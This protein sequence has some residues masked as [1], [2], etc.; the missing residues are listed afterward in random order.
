[1]ADLSRPWTVEGM[2]A[3]LSLSGEHL[4]RLCHRQLN[5]SPMEHV[6][7]LRMIRAAAMLVGSTSKIDAIA[8]ATGYSTRFAFSTAFGRYYGTSPAQYRK[9]LHA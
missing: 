2:A 7:H 3:L 4:R 8:A 1:M 6:T 5:R 9:K